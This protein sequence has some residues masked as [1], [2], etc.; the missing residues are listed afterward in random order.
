MTRINCIPVNELHQK[1]L[2]AEY[3]ELPR[4]FSLVKSNIEKNKPMS[5][6]PKN[7]TMGTGHVKFF[8]NKL[9]YL[10]KRFS[11]LISEMLKRGY[12]PSFTDNLNNLYRQ[13]IPSI[14]WNDWTPT[15]IDMNINLDRINL[16]LQEMQERKN[17]S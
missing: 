10:Q 7:Y 8:Y 13:Q 9:D 3:R 2:I 4:V 17:K 1:H 16:R 11:Q 14:Y 5:D 15:N 6:I 12:N